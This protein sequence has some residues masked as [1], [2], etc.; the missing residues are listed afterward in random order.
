MFRASAH[1]VICD[2]IHAFPSQKV[3]K[4]P[5]TSKGILGCGINFEASFDGSAE[6]SANSEAQI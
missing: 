5:S 4:S 2:K 3:L 6:H 1:I